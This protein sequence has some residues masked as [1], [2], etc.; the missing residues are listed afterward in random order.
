[1]YNCL[2][3]FGVLHLNVDKSLFFWGCNLSLSINTFVTRSC[4]WLVIVGYPWLWC[5]LSWYI[6]CTVSEEKCHLHVIVHDRALGSILANN[7]LN[8]VSKR[9]SSHSPPPILFIFQSAIS[10]AL[11]FFF[12]LSIR[13]NVSLAVFTE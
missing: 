11:D 7:V 1:M 5:Q 13:K 9:Y 8:K 3:L 12:F 2:I 10:L 6:D 4:N